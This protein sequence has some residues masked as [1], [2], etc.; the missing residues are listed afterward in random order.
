MKKIQLVLASFSS[1]SIKNS[2]DFKLPCPSGGFF[3]NL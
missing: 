1:F 2:L 3:V